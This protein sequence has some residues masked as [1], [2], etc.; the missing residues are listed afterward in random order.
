MN[1]ERHFYVWTVVFV[2]LL[3]YPPPSTLAIFY[4]YPSDNMGGGGGIGNKATPV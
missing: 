2:A 1:L 3:N 4:F